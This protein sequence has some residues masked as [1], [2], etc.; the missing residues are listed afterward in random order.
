MSSSQMRVLLIEDNAGD[1]RLIR[2]LLTHAA[3]PSCRLEWHS[4]LEAGLERLAQ[5]GI[6][7]VLLDL[8]LPDSRGPETADRVMAQSPGIPIV[9]LTGL[10]DETT[11]VDTVHHG[12]QDYWTKGKVDGNLLARSLRYAIER[13]RIDEALRQRTLELQVRNEELDAYAHTVAHDLRNPLSLIR[14]FAEFLSVD[15]ATAAEQEQCITTILRMAGKMSSIID[16]LL[17]LSEV[18]K[19][20][21]AIAPLD[22]PQI[23]AEARECLLPMIQTYQS[24]IVIASDSECGQEASMS[25]WPAALGHGPWVEEVWTN[26]LSNAIKYGGRPPRVELGAAAQADGMVR[27]WVRDNGPGIARED[28][29]QLFAPF[30]MLDKTRA[31]GHGLG[32]SIVRHIVEKLGGQVGVESDGVLG[33]GSVFFFTLPGHKAQEEER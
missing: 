8:S 32:L 11:A 10:D 13:K 6:D 9:V 23:V 19:A 15:G 22:M 14:G 30:L 24:E 28:Q 4:R 25:A 33:R 7:A 12:A 20:E 18:R 27:F 31:S 16:E 3:G 1:A 26:Y 17:L 21:V 29:R 2:E 5:G